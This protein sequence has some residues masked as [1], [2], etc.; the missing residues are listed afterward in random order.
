M[1]GVLGYILLR[2]EQT[3]EPLAV[4]KDVDVVESLAWNSI[5]ISESMRSRDEEEEKYEREVKTN[6]K[7]K[8]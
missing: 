3:F 2:A 6:G 4:M 8:E 7:K 1:K 5:W